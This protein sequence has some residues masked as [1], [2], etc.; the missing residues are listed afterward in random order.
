MVS[1]TS[2]GEAKLLHEG[3]AIPEQPF[4]IHAPV[5]PVANRCHP[6]AKALTGRGNARAIRERHG[7][8][9]GASHDTAD[10]RPAAGAEANRMYLDGDARGVDEQRLQIRDVLV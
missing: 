5:D 7:P 1:T 6:D 10:R 2:L 3:V 4:V 9:K 8:R